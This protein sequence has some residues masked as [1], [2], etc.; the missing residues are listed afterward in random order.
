MDI[1]DLTSGAFD[2]IGDKKIKPQGGGGGIVSAITDPISSAIGTDGGGGGI[3]GG[4]ADI[5]PGPSIGSTLA[6]VDP[7]PAIGSGLADVDEFVGREIR[8][9][10]YRE[11]QGQPLASD[12][13]W[14]RGLPFEVKT[15]V[16][17]HDGATNDRVYDVSYESALTAAGFTVEVVGNQGRG[18]AMLRVEAVRRVFPQVWMDVSCEETGLAALAAYHE[19]KDEVRGIGLGPEHDWSSHGSDAFG[20]IAIY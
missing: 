17:P 10:G 20:L 3:L 15:C 9:V 12:I 7:G 19:R 18:A 1:P 8:I 13:Q 5:D 14:L 16:L 11:T 6:S 2:H 4:L